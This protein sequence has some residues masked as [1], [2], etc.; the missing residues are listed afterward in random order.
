MVQNR[1]FR[2]K[3]ERL[4][5]RTR[6]H[7][8]G[9]FRFLTV[10]FNFFV[11]LLS[12]N[13]NLSPARLLHDKLKSS[14]VVIWTVHGAIVRL[15]LDASQPSQGQRKPKNR[16][17]TRTGEPLLSLSIAL[18]LA[19][20]RPRAHPPK[21]RTSKP[22]AAALGF[23]SPRGCARICVSPRRHRQRHRH[24]QRQRQRQR[25][26]RGRSGG[27]SIWRRD[28]PSCRRASPS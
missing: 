5:F 13:S 1:I 18:S 21:K 14:A 8:H 3:I 15:P 26:W 9:D 12:S 6:D 23:A 28:G 7:V 19:S 25:R 10:Y 22:P 17:A 27:R 20:R 16:P 2:N 24:R 4:H 11:D